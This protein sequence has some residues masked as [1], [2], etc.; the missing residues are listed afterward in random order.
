MF[1]F[2]V[3]SLYFPFKNIEYIRSSF[4]G[5]KCAESQ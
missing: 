2:N 3:V 1:M 4:T 5:V